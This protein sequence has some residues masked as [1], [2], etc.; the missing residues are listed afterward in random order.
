[1]SVRTET[2][3]LGKDHIV[4]DR[5]WPDS[6]R[7]RRIMPDEDEAKYMDSRI[8]VAIVEGRWKKLKDELQRGPA[9]RG[10]TLAQFSDQY[11][12]EYCKLRNRC[13]KDCPGNAS[14]CTRV[15]VHSLEER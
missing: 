14:S 15:A 8:Y 5:R 10:V 13:W 11:L 6:T 12:E 1:M 4:V 9:I 2:D 7:F 3:K